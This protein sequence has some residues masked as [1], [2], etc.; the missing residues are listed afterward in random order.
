MDPGF[1]RIA[2]G[3]FAGEGAPP[4]LPDLPVAE[5]ASAISRNHGHG[6]MIEPHMTNAARASSR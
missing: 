6:T 1:R 3:R 4:Q 2:W 5:A